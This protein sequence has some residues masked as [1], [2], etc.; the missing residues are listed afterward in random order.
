[1][2]VTFTACETTPDGGS[3]THVV[4]VPLELVGVVPG[5][6]PLWI[7]PLVPALGV[8]FVET[9]VFEEESGWHN[10]PALQFVVILEGVIESETTDGEVRRFG[11]GSVTLAADITGR[12]HRARVVQSPLRIMFVPLAERPP[13]WSGPSFEPAEIRAFDESPGI[14]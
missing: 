8:H 13:F 4:D 11:P 9:S 2:A 6:S 3:S 1:M 14:G 5:E 7:S 12:G 10:A